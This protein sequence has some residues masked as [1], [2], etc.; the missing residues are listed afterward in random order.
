MLQIQPLFAERNQYASL[1]G[2]EGLF[3]EVL[4]LSM[5]NRSEAEKQQMEAW[6]QT[7]GRTTSLHGA[8]IDNNPASANLEIRRIS[9]QDCH[10]SCITAKRI[11]AKNVV[12]HGSCFPFLR[13]YYLENWADLSAEFYTELAEQYDLNLF[14]E[15]SQD[16]DTTPLRE[17][18][19]RLRHPNIKV[20]LDIGHGDRRK[21][22]IG[23]KN[24]IWSYGQRSEPLRSDRRIYDRRTGADIREDQ[25][26]DPRGTG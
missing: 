6:Y 26:R 24:Q 4:E 8:F 22:R 18:M 17:L 11:G 19:R 12:F 14:I 7:T 23:K 10:E 1:A 2:Q 16:L 9:R 5:G 13:G 25:M 15:N 21:Y 3:F 20:C